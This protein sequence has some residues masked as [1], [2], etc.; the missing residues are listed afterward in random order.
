ML[1]SF[2]GGDLFGEIFGSYPIKVL[3][4]HGWGRDHS[5]YA[6]LL[7]RIAEDKEAALASDCGI[8][9]PDLPGFGATPPPVTAWGSQEYAD[10]MARLLDSEVGEPVVVIGHSFGGRIAVK[11]A[12]SRPDLVRSLV[13][14]GAPLVR[15]AH[16]GNSG[17]QRRKQG[18]VAPVYRLGRRLY[19]MGIISEGYM[20]NL[21]RKYGSYDYAHAT[22]VMR[23]I[24]VRLLAENYADDLVGIACPTWLVW[25]AEDREVPLEVAMEVDKM[26]PETTLTEL[27][28]VGHLVPVEAGDALWEVVC[29]LL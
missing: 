26:I 6:T 7:S 10:L 12:A 20:E 5:D 8:L 2:I 14:T 22:G 9:V 27:P 1:R 15:T 3:A 13:L 19:K 21:R 28:G 29:K 25:G 11:L 17:R 4:L 18:R 24:L 23:E 16:L